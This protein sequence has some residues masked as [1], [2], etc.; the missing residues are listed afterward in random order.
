MTK[1]IV[2]ILEGNASLDSLDEKAT[3]SG[4]TL[5]TSETRAYDTMAYND[6]MMKFKKMVMPSE[7][8]SS[9]SEIGSSGP[10]G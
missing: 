6:D 7:E 8:F 9:S 10:Y 2:R 3:R 5:N 1:Q 4:S